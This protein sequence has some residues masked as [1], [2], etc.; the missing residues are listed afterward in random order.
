[1]VLTYCLQK[2]N[3]MGDA[4]RFAVYDGERRRILSLRVH[5]LR[6][7]V[8]QVASSSTSLVTY[9]LMSSIEYRRPS[10]VVVRL[11]KAKPQI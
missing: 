9:C 1:M 4:G 2:E 8:L 10:L 11:A 6:Q 3:I 7:Y 5:L